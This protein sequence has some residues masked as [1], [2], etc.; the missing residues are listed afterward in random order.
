M[1]EGEFDSGETTDD[2]LPRSPR[3]LAVR[4]LIAVAVLVVIAFAGAWL[5][6]DRIANRIVAGQLAKYDLPATYKIDHVGPERQ[7]LSNIVVGNPQHPDLTIE[8]AV[9]TLDYDFG[10]PTLGSVR[11]VRPRVYGRY[12]DGKLS[13]GSLDTVLNAPSSGPPGL[14]KLDLSLVD[15]RGVIESDHGPIGFK[16]EGAGPLDSGFKGILAVIAPELSIGGCE[17]DRATLFGKIT[18][19]GGKPNLTGPVRLSRLACPQQGVVLSNAAVALDAG[20]SADLATIEGTGTLDTGQVAMS[21]VAANGVTGTVHGAWGKQGLTSDYTL[22]ARG[23]TL[24][25]ALAAIVTFDGTMR[26]DRGFTNVDLRSS[27][28]GNGVRMGAGLDHAL[29]SGQE[30]MRETLLG[31]MLGQ[32]RVALAREGRAS[33]LTAELAARRTGKVDSLVIPQASLRGGSGATLLSLSQVQLARTDGGAPHFS[34]NVATGGAG[35]P[36]I[37]GRMERAGGGS[38]VLRLHMANYSVGDGQLAVP[39][40]VIAQGRGGKLGF[41]GRAIASGP[42]PG[43]SAQALA[44]PI[45]GSW[46]PGAG[47]AMWRKC[48]AVSFEQLQF[49]S[50]SLDQHALQLCPKGGQPILRSAG[51]GVAMAAEIPSLDLS[52]TLAETPIRLTGGAVEI[53]YPGTIDASDMEVALGPH[54][55]V[56]EF[57]IANLSA[58]FGEEL[59]GTIADSDVRL[60]A[61]PL[62]LLGAKGSWRYADGALSLTDG[63]FILQDRAKVQ[64]FDPLAGTGGTLTL[65]DN[66]IHADAVLRAPKPQREVMA[67]NIVHNLSKGTGHADLSVPGLVFDKQLQP[68]ELSYL[69]L[70]VIANA[71]G[72]VQG[73]GRIDWNP[74]H[75]TSSGQFSSDGVDFAAAFGPVSGASGT[76]EFSDLLGMTTAPDQKLYVKSVNPG[77]EV[78]DGVVTYAISN[79]ELLSVAGARWPFMGGSLV[80]RPTKLKLG[81]SEERHYVFEITGLDA[82]KFVQHWNFQ[83][84]AATGTFDGT[85]PIT[86]DQDGNGRIESGLLI[87]RAPGGNVS[88]LGDLTYKDKG[89]IANFAFNALKSLDYKQ[90]SIGMDGPLTGEIVTK[91]RFDGVTQGAGAKR[92][93]VTRQLAKLP[94]RFNVNIAAPFYKLIGSLRSMYDPTAVRDPRDLGLLDAN[95]KPTQAVVDVKP[96]SAL[97]AEPAPSPQVPTEPKSKTAVEPTVQTHESEKK[98]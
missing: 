62:D 77:I 58:K 15:A 63:S 89:A 17:A 59:S 37:T 36:R 25:Q 54:D 10:A 47:L 22:A 44:V 66:V 53:S 42:L 50:L 67:V 73:S 98:P 61:I 2:V 60:S 64:R 28:E 88:Y 97:P 9:V 85:L 1:A 84:L 76:V 90:M 43:G 30:A 74:N 19:N 18:T 34:G 82:A 39:E 93:F 86:F 4:V 83:N 94:I 7:V 23:L 13:F 29:G 95:G 21:G 52:G 35:L 26:A 75:V 49:A 3:V 33:R 20:S 32:V 71:K 68:D 81:I 80:L 78:N 48:T 46:S 56:N 27:V 12:H 24:P 87:A 16:A 70:G 38:A 41:A 57:R 11:L 51:G 40:L 96:D 5:A 6:R 91:V 14:P 8:R 45:D 65:K 79:G 31:P 92:N 72:T 55:A 69:M